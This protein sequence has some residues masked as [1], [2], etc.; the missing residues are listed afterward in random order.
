[1]TL[2]NISATVEVGTTVVPI[3]D[4]S[5]IGAAAIFKNNGPATVFIGGSTPGIT[6]VLSAGWSSS[7]GYPLNPGDTL[8]LPD[9]GLNIYGVTASGVAYVS[10][11]YPMS[12]S[13]PLPR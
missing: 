10:W 6:P 13:E 2:Q 5:S 4:M 3:L 7:T 9:Q 1:M 12:A 8:E 11:L